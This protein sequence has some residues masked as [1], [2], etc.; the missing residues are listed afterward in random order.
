M[1]NTTARSPT[2]S[3]DLATYATAIKNCSYYSSKNNQ[4]LKTTAAKNT[5]NTT[6]IMMALGEIGISRGSSSVQNNHSSPSGWLT[7]TAICTQPER[8]GTAS[9]LTAIEAQSVGHA[10]S[11]GTG[12]Q[13]TTNRLVS[14]SSPNAGG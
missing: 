13:W 6:A 7:M 5:N 11:D 2:E 8:R 4:N 3:H 10:M 14:L 9:T 1:T 12:R